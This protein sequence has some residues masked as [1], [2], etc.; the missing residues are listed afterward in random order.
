MKAEAAKIDQIK[1]MHESEIE[2]LKAQILKKSQSG[3]ETLLLKEQELKSVRK[4]LE[5]ANQKQKIFEKQR[6]DFEDREKQMR[7]D[8]EKVKIYN[9]WQ[10]L[11]FLLGASAASSRFRI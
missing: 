6:K 2:Y 11:H 5:E 1:Q 8:F 9:T 7:I 4:E 10:G 3:S